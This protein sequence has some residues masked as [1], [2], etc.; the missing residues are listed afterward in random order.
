MM[1]NA[2]TRVFSG[3]GSS[4]VMKLCQHFPAGGLAP[5]SLV[6]MEFRSNGHGWLM[7]LWM[8]IRSSSVRSVAKDRS[9]QQ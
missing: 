3:L 8:T 4:S 6:P 5:E 2:L 9:G 7:L 1:V